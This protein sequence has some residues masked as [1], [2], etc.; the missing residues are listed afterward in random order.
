VPPLL[1]PLDPPEL[2]PLL[3]PLEL[4]LVLP[5]LLPLLEPL[6][7]PLVLPELPLLDPLELPE[8]PELLPLLEE[9][10]EPPLVLPEP[11]LLEP[12]VLPEPVP[13][14]P[15]LPLAA[16]LL[17]VEPL[18]DPD[19]ASP[20]ASGPTTIAD[21]SARP[22][23]DRFLHHAALRILLPS[24]ARATTRGQVVN[25]SDQGPGADRA[26]QRPGHLTMTASG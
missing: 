1:L 7:L 16:P 25:W 9:P 5:E 15:P 17:L 21:N 26:G 12:L 24:K 23:N 14:D 3:E 8:L 19:V 4:P 13:L 2:L 11:L 18:P 20:Q 10:L 22:E 6:E